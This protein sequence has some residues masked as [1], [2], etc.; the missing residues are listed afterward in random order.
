MIR[1]INSLIILTLLSVSCS[2]NS[3][4][5]IKDE[6]VHSD[7]SVHEHSSEQL[8]L[9]KGEKWVVVPKMMGYIRDMENE[10]DAFSN[11]EIKD[12]E[13]LSNNLLISIDS[14]TSNCTMQGEA[15]DELHKWLVPYIESVNQL[16]EIDKD[17]DKVEKIDA[18]Q[19]SY[20]TFN[21]FFK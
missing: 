21:K 16:S 10:I 12:Y 8:Q 11:T 18:L 19:N 3:N 13:Q 9:N 5:T 6:L 20:L 17:N 7:E 15:H 2:S 14:L 4:E 1:V